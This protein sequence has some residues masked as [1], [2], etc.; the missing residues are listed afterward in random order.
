MKKLYPSLL[1]LF[2]LL[3]CS[4]SFGQVAVMS[5]DF[6][7]Y[8]AG[9]QLACQNP[10]DWTTWSS[11][12]CDATEDPLVS[13]SQ[14]YNGS[15]S[16][17]IVSNNDLVSVF[18]NW[19]TGKYKISF[20]MYI[21]S[22]SEAYFN[23]LHEFLG[24]NTV[25][26]GMQAYYPL[27]GIGT[28]DA[29]VASAATFN[30]QYDTWMLVELVVDLDNDN[31]EFFMNG[32]SVISWIWHLGTFG[33]G[34]Q[35]QLGG[36]D[37]FG[38]D[39]TALASAYIDDFNVYDLIVPVELTSFIGN[40][41]NSGNVVLN[42]ST[43][44]ET[45]NQMFEIQRRTN[46]NEYFTIGYVEGAGT[47][48]EPRDYNYTDKTTTTGTYYYRLKQ[49]DFDGRF[50]YSDE[51]EV[52][53]KGPLNFTLEQNYPNPFNPST[54]ISYSIPEAGY[55]KLSVYNVVGEEVAV[56]V[57][58][59]VDAGFYEVNFDAKNLPSGAYIYKLQANNS[60]EVKKMLLTK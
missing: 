60:F 36:A 21:P 45:N 18:P 34:V 4:I 12:P 49:I 52:E 59:Q 15:N 30:F 8:V 56:L 40:V 5:D 43:A 22:G 41:N 42:W 48:T 16:V 3:F 10:V 27:G 54:K 7:S 39:Q 51:V 26:W 28:I 20:Q 37:F 50:E 32:S 19:T 57:D 9:Q 11:L 55:V 35:D 44:T 31:A 1:I 6:D 14:A 17:N 23:V 13:S 58:K 2:V 38:Y 47:T 46:E 33:T 53:V 29:G 25:E 24:P